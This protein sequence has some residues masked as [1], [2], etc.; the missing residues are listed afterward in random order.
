MF[1]FFDPNS[2]CFAKYDAFCLLIFNYACLGVRLVAIEEV[3]NYRKFVCIKNIFEN[4]WWQDAYPSSYLSGFA[5]GHKLQKPSK[6]SDIFQSLVAPSV[7]FFFTKRQN[8]K[9][10]HITMAPPLNTLLKT[11]CGQ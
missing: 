4:G 3:R 10:G 6:E 1:K 5:P 7:L 11:G 9:G 2:E 8:Q